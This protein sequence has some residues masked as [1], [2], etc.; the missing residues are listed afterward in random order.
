MRRR[1]SCFRKR[2]LAQF[3]NQKNAMAMPFLGV[4]QG[5]HFGR[6][7][8]RPFSPRE[9][10][11]LPWKLFRAE[12]AREGVQSDWLLSKAPLRGCLSQNNVNDNNFYLGKFPRCAS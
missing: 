4:M 10:S 7:R 1:A 11:F 9:L 8:A 6:G 12:F 2:R 3:R 5:A